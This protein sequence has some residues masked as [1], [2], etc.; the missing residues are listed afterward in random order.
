[1][2]VTYRQAHGSNTWHFRE[3]CAYWPHAEF[4]Q[5]S[6][7]PGTGVCCV[8]CTYW[9]PSHRRASVDPT[10]E[11]QSTVTAGHRPPSSAQF[12]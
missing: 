6:H 11:L 1:M 3:D 2:P 12:R 5:Q 7:T 10:F 4:D 8:E 9:P